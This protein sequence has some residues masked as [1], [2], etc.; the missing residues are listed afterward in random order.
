MNTIDTTKFGQKL[1]EI[2][3]K[4]ENVKIECNSEVTGYDIEESTGIVKAVSIGKLKSKIHCDQ[5]IL[6]NGPQAP[7][8]IWDHFHSV[9]PGIHGLGYTFDVKFDKEFP[10]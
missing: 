4:L 7:R 5:V 9:L 2:T 3:D 10:V 6:C 1:W 8:H